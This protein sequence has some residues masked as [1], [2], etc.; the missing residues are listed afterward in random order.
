MKRILFLFTLGIF[1]FQQ[2]VIAC[3]DCEG[4]DCKT[5]KERL[6]IGPL[7]IGFD[8]NYLKSVGGFDDEGD[9][10][11]YIGGD[12]LTRLNE[13][14]Y[15]KFN[16]GSFNIGD[17]RWRWGVEADAS[18][19]QIKWTPGGQIPNAQGYSENGTV[20]SFGPTV[21]SRRLA[22]TSIGTLLGIKYQLDLTEDKSNVTDKQNALGANLNFNFRPTHGVKLFAGF[23]YWYTFPRTETQQV[24]NPQTFQFVNK[25]FDYD[26]G[27][28]LSVFGG[29][30]YKWCWS[31]CGWGYAGASVSY[32]NKSEIIFDDKPIDKSN[33]NLL[34]LIPEVGF[35]GRNFPLHVSLSGS[36]RNEYNMKQGVVAFSG[37]NANKPSLALEMNV[38]YRF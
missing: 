35:R 24:F 13:I 5:N 3:D 11:E 20:I 33:A 23:D 32:W 12:Y 6:H 27:D 34:S 14:I 15:G 9:K 2:N 28:Q 17:S 7:K 16:A 26:A 22:G 18:L 1:A 21:S 36:Y 10:Y 31:D 25:D 30:D 19:I 8:I 37:V 4:E 29:A 38:N